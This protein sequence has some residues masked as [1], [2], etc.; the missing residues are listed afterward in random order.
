MCSLLLA[1]MYALLP[2]SAQGPEGLPVFAGFNTRY[3]M[4]ALLVAAPAVAWLATRWPRARVAI[5]AALAVAIIDGLAQKLHAP[6]G[7]SIAVALVLLAVS[8]AGV[9]VW[10]RRSRLRPA[11]LRLAVA[12]SAVL[13]ALA[14][15]AVGHQT[16]RAFNEDRYAGVDATFDWVRAHAASDARIALA[17][18]WSRGIGSPF[19]MFGPRLGNEVAYLGR[20]EDEMLRRH[21]DPQAFARAFETGGYDLLIVGRG[22]AAA[23]GSPPA[24]D[25][26]DERWASQAGLVELARSDTFTLFGHARRDGA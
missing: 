17:G 5:E 15:V 20:W 24:A 11:Q 23:P 4:P 19:P 8:A 21:D 3:V 6:V 1:L 13:L 18:G 26:R 14:A 22:F 12:T 9:A 7:R 10:R 16:Q 2:Y 25:V